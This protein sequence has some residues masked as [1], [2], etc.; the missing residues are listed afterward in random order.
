MINNDGNN[1]DID[2]DLVLFVDHYFPHFVDFPQLK[3]VPPA[4][5]VVALKEI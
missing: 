4:R 2:I 1:D 3:H 5:S